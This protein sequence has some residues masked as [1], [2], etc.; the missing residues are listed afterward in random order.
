MNTLLM[1]NIIISD[2]INKDKWI[3]L[4]VKYEELTISV[5]FQVGTYYSLII[6]N[7]YLNYIYLT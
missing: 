2:E 4:S 1:M 3:N 7:K 6:R 5:H